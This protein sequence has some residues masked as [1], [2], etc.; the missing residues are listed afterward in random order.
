MH[1]DEK[2]E[3]SSQGSSEDRN[4]LAQTPP[5]LEIDDLFQKS[6]DEKMD[7]E[8]D[9]AEK[10]DQATSSYFKDVDEAVASENSEANTNHTAQI[11]QQ[12]AQGDGQGQGQG[13][14]TIINN[15]IQAPSET[16]NTIGL[17]GFILSIVAFILSWIPL[18]GGLLWLVGAILSII[19]LFKAPRGFAIAG[20]V[21]SF[22]MIFVFLFFFM[23]FIMLAALS[24][25]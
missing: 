12:T 25:Y 17:T 10:L 5:A 21:I 9:Y 18:L 16:S 7:S 4:L 23:G 3:V 20:T 22:L 1:K 8:P 24:P 15:Y 13:G 11:N 19:G 6:V 2:R 14:T